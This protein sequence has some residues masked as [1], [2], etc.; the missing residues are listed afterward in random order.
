MKRSK[1]VFLLAPLTLASCGG[2]Y[3][4]QMD[5]LKDFQ[6]CERKATGS[7]SAAHFVW[8]PPGHYVYPPHRPPS[9]RYGFVPGPS[10]GGFGLASH[11]FAASVAA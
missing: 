10:R 2:E 1:A 6:T 8:V 9:I 3:P 4:T 7:G 5:C 11:A